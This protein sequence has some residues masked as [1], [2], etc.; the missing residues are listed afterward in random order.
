MELDEFAVGTKRKGW[1]K[2]G[3]KKWKKIKKEDR[4]VFSDEAREYLEACA[5]KKKAK[6]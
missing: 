4:G 6:K 2:V 3:E 1:L 5:K